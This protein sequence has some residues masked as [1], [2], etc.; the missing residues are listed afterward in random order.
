[1]KQRHL[2]IGEKLLSLTEPQV[3]AIINVTPDS[4]YTASRLTDDSA[5]LRHVETCLTNGAAILDIG[6]CSTRPGAEQPDM[7][8]E[9]KRL[10]PALQSIR[11]HFPD[12]LLSLDTYRSRIAY[13]AVDSFGPMCINDISGG[14]MDDDMF[15]QVAQLHVPYI[16]CT[17]QATVGQTIATWQRGIDI[18]HRMGCRDIIL[19]PGFGFGKDIPQNYT[20]L[21]HLQEFQSLDLPLLVGLSRKSMLYKPLRLTPNDVL[22]AT[23][24]A[25]MTALLNGADILRVHDVQDA[26]Q[27]ITMYNNLSIL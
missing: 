6:G 4:F 10:Q 21:R 24:A 2:K 20:I 22:A 18:L 19:D 25:N 16:F 13:R 3:M 12:A 1:M 26:V 23:N 7:E 15:N 17:A 5:L 8:T 14:T 27:T 11:N 9:W